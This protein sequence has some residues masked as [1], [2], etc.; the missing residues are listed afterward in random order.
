LSIFL[1]SGEASGD[2]YTANL[3]KAL[4]A[5]GYDDDIWGMGAVESR[6]AGVRVEWHGERLQ[7]LGLTE[8]I[9]SIPSILK[10]IKEVA[11]RIMDVRPQAVVVADSPDYH[12]RLI[13]RLRSLGYRGRIFY[14]SPPSV[15]AWR[16][17]RTKKLKKYVNECFPLYEFEHK[18][19]QEHGCKSY[20]T[21][22]PLLEEFSEKNDETVPEQFI[23]D[24]KLVAF[25]PG[26]RSSE[27]KALLPVME[28]SASGLSKR[29][30]HPVF[31]VAPGLDPKTREEMIRRFS[32][33]GVNFYEGSGRSLL[34]AAQCSVSASGTITV[35]S[36]LAGK[37]MIVVY[38]LHPVTAFIAR[39]I[40]KT[41]RFSMANI[42]AG[43]DLYPELFQQDCTPEHITAKTLS[44][45]E[46][47][48]RM[49]S[50]AKAK[51][52]Q[53]RALLGEPGVYDRWAERIM[54]NVS[55]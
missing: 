51:M 48:E 16:S 3:A 30:W 18:F 12:M 19:L 37:Y 2:H 32:R 6:E 14:I 23:G 39:R 13:A 11:N 24:D 17:G 45:L 49:H 50:A 42:I 41:R 26:S 55:C 47:G 53:V 38:K 35:E 54:A 43:E 5:R 4:R 25:M 10:L 7:L 22:A 27:V 1:S 34:E 46:G 33:N 36:M 9:S 40:V 28:E 20:W 21:G 31:S 15:W 29:G 52:E 44:W 8:V